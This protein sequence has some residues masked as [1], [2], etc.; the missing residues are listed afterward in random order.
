M[1]RYDKQ[2]WSTSERHVLRD[3]YY[4]LGMEHLLEV[5]PGRTPNSIRKQ[6]AY[7]KKRGWYFKKELP[8]L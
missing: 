1:K 2:P 7:L 8:N 3:Y 4:V 5:L 6:V